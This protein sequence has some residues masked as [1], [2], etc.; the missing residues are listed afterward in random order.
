MTNKLIAYLKGSGL[1]TRLLHP[2]DEFW[3]RRFGVDTIG[4]LREV[5]EYDDPNW[6]GA[7]VPTQYRR[8]IAAF[9]H[10][11]LGPDDVVVDLGCGLGRAVFSAAWLGARRSVGVEIDANL[12]AKARQSQ[13]NSRLQDRDIEFVCAPAQTYSLDDATLIYMY[14]PFGSGIM[15][16]VIAHL[17]QALA[18]RPRKLRIV[19]ENPLQ[20]AVLEASRYLKHTGGWPSGTAGSPHPVSF[21]ETV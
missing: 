16:E 20:S 15:Q 12:V 7:Y 6:R 1:K 21:W 17:E 11:N 2:I 13:R 8:I 19:Y 18:K 3:D 4:Y 14:N 9:R 10:V 5:G